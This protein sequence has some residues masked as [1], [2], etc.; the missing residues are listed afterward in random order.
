MTPWPVNGVR[1]ACVNSF[2]YG[3]ANA[4]CILDHPSSVLPD[5]EPKYPGADINTAR[6]NSQFVDSIA[7]E[8]QQLNGQPDGD[9]PSQLDGHRG[10]LDGEVKEPNGQPKS[11]LHTVKTC[12]IANG[13]ATEPTELNGTQFPT[14]GHDTGPKREQHIAQPSGLVPHNYAPLANGTNKFDAGKDIGLYTMRPKD[15]IDRYHEI[16]GTKIR[17]T[18]SS[19]ASSRALVV[20]PFSSHTENSLHAN[21]AAMALGASKYNVADLV[22]TLSDRRSRFFQRG[23]AIANSRNV[24]EALNPNTMYFGKSPSAQT[25]RVG[26]VFTGQGAQWPGMGAELFSQF[27]VF[28]STIQYMDAI[29]AKL[30]VRPAWTIENT[31]LASA[32]VSRIQEPE[33]SQTICTALQIALVN[34]LRSWNIQPVATVGHSSGEIAAAYAAGAHTA[35]ESIILAFLRG[36]VVKD[37]KQIGCM[38]AVGLSAEAVLPFIRLYEAKVQIAAVNSPDAVTLSG[39]RAAI[40]AILERLKEATI[41]T[42]LLDTGNQAYHSYHMAALGAHYEHLA[43]K[44]LEE[45][46]EAVVQEPKLPDAIHWQSSVEPSRVASSFRLGPAYWRRNLESC[47]L[48]SQAIE[49]LAADER[50]NVDLY[51]ELGPHPAL[52]SSLRQ[53]YARLSQGTG[54]SSPPF[55]PSLAR[56][57]DSL[58]SMLVLSGHLFVHNTSVNLVATNATDRFSSNR[59]DLVRGTFCRDL[60][61]YQYDYGPILYHENRFSR[62]L[63]LRTHLRHDILGARQP[64]GVHNRP[65]WRNVLRLKDVPWL[66]DHKVGQYS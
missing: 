49:T 4:H 45:I 17:I 23:F 5:H 26:F 6:C 61:S 47:V 15:N 8:Y 30:S 28:K 9:P 65:S 55:L 53:I 43:H 27:A 41:F 38:L 34:L 22:Y 18:R 31:L 25:Q 29:L 10:H 11:E 56:N 54:L 32:A 46:S 1:R 33:F 52:Q 2:G 62:D 39:D 3:G 58:R 7:Q 44:C 19:C 12:I 24:A 37:N 64:G 36:Q 21:I 20:I 57:E 48:F 42:K 16:C 35:A 50:A 51:I 66:D 40:L 60:P 63:R 14:S 59:L 13:A